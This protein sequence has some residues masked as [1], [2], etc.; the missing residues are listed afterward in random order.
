MNVVAVGDIGLVGDAGDDAK[1]LLQALGE[2]VGGGLHGSAVQGE[3]HVL[4]GLPG[5]GSLVHMLHDLHGE[6]SGLR[7]GVGLAGHVLDALIEAGIA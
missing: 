4:L 2:A 6:G 3:V 1:A 7:I 5:G